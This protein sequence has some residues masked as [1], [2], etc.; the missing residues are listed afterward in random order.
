M[1]FCLEEC[2]CLARRFVLLRCPG[3]EV[4]SQEKQQGSLTELSVKAQ[5]DVGLIFPDT[6]RGERQNK[7]QLI[8]VSEHL[9]CQRT[10]RCKKIVEHN[11]QICCKF[12][13]MISHLPSVDT[14]CLAHVHIQ[15]VCGRRALVWERT[16]Y[17]LGAR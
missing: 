16:G 5:A 6:R 14:Y 10:L 12:S 1:S 2:K 17:I 8:F 9:F 4:N 7:L 13:D 11:M 15:C 3:C